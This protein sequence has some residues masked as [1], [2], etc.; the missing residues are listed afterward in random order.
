ML[1]HSRHAVLFD[2]LNPGA[3]RG[4]RHDATPDEGA[5]RRSSRWHRLAGTTGAP[6]ADAALARCFVLALAAMVP[7]SSSA[8][9]RS[10]ARADVEASSRAARSRTS[11]AL[12]SALDGTLRMR[13]EH[14]FSQPPFGRTHPRTRATQLMW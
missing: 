10:L 6:G 13:G 5:R 14:H 1:P 7:R 3:R 12:G 4:G 8:C 9:S 2:D 11:G